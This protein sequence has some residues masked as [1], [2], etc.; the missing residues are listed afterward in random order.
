VVPFGFAHAARQPDPGVGVAQIGL[1]HGVVERLAQRGPQ[2]LR[3]RR[4]HRADSPVA[5]PHRRVGGGPAGADLGVAFLQRR[6]HG[7]DVAAPEVLY[8]I[9]D[10]Q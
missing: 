6:V 10:D 7:F 3:A 1:V 5:G 4:A 9:A 8:P 2:P